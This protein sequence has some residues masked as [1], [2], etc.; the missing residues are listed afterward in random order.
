MIL[1]NSCNLCNCNLIQTSLLQ[2]HV[3]TTFETLFLEFHSKLR[4]MSR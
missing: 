4:G 1:V 2:L 3:M